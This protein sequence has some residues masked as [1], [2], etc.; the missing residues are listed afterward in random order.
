[1]KLCIF[2]P[3]DINYPEVDQSQPE[4][5]REHCKCTEITGHQ[6]DPGNPTASGKKQTPKPNLHL[7]RQTYL[8]L[9]NY[10]H[11]HSSLSWHQIIE[12]SN[13]SSNDLNA[14]VTFFSSHLWKEILRKSWGTVNWKMISRNPRTRWTEQRSHKIVQCPLVLQIF[15]LR[16]EDC[17]TVVRGWPGYMGPAKG[18]PASLHHDHFYTVG[19]ITLF[20]HS[21]PCSNNTQGEMGLPVLLPGIKKTKTGIPT[22]AQQKWI[23]LASMRMHV[24]SLASPSGLRIWCCC[25]LWC[26]AQTWLRSDIA[27][28][29]A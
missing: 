1:M 29:V 10:P 23:W 3:S 9:K 13:C 18:Q 11:V 17:A 19:Q 14:S 25:E 24:W 5:Q 21:F 16:L 8:W 27:V 12:W 2:S 15:H 4:N 28:T 7:A 6:L 26:R 20:I 22:V